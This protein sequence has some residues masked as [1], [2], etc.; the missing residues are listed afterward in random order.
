MKKGYRAGG[1]ACLLSSSLCDTMPNMKRKTRFDI[2]AALLLAS[3]LL[4][5]FALSPMMPKTGNWL[6]VY[7]AV[8]V[9][10]ALVLGLIMRRLVKRFRK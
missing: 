2:I 7:F 8:L 5:W 6:I 4:A 10:F 1:K 3:V 9:F